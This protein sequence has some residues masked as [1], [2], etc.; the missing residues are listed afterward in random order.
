MAELALV[1]LATAQLI[2][3]V[4]FVSNYRR[5]RRARAQWADQLAANWG[6]ERRAGESTSQL[7][8]RISDTACGLGRFQ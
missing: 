1:A 5:R 7:E 3:V 4:A 2:V 6:L 8:R